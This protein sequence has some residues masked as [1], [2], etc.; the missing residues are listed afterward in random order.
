MVTAGAMPQTPRTRLAQWCS[1]VCPIEDRTPQPVTTTRFTS[2]PLRRCEPAQI[3]AASHGGIAH[4][5]FAGGDVRYHAAFGRDHSAFADGNVIGDADLAAQHRIVPNRHAAGDAALRDQDAVPADHTVVA[6]LH[7]VIDLG[8]LA[9]HGVAAAA[10]VDRGVDAD[11]DVVLHDDAA[12]LRHLDVAVRARLIAEAV[13]SD[14]AAGVDDDGVA[15]QR[16]HD[17]G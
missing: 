15:D 2:L 9:D 8:P 5:F 1:A 10:A 7:E 6:D 16:M 4:P 14:V 17:R 11:L 3:F 13:V 12:E